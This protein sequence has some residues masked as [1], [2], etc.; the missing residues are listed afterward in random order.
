MSYKFCLEV[1]NPASCPIGWITSGVC[2]CVD[3]AVPSSC[4]SMPWGLQKNSWE[5]SQRA[6]CNWW[7]AVW[8]H[9]RERDYWC[10]IHH[11]PD[12][13]KVS[14]EEEAV[15][16][17]FCWPREGLWSCTKGGCQWALR[18]A[19]IEELLVHAVMALFAGAKTHLQTACGNI[20]S[21]DGKVG[22]HQG[23]VLSRLL[24]IIV[25]MSFLRR[26]GGISM[27]TALC[28]WPG[29]DGWEWAGTDGKDVFMASSPSGK[30]FESECWKVQ[31][32]GIFCWCR[33]DRENGRIPL[34]SLLCRC[35]SKLN[36][37]Q[38]LYKVGPPQM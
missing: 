13:R 36:K 1:T 33:W 27:G 4:W 5:E 16:L 10:H 32:H 7:N 18:M 15:V 29:T 30:G 9:A 11:A 31:G 37:M 2:V 8:L 20:E 19:G 38:H 35:W 6:G 12:A 17:C 34:W 28:R 22:V 25:M 21:F 23:S 3:L 26:L 24:F 14:S